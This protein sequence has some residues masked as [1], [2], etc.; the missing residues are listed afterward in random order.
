MTKDISKARH[1]AKRIPR[2]D[3]P[4]VRWYECSLPFRPLIA[5]RGAHARRIG[6]AGLWMAGMLAATVLV[7]IWVDCLRVTG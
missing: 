5:Q 7:L 3:I 4:A 1:A 2:F 6:S